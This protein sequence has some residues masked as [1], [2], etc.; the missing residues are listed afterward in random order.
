[1]NMFAWTL[2]D[3]T[4]GQY[5]SA[6]LRFDGGEGVDSEIIFIIAIHNPPPQKLLQWGSYLLL[7]IVGVVLR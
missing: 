2:F 5:I 4:L 1:M 7:E 6:T 3:W